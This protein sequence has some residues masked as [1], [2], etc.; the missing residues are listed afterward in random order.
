MTLAGTRRREALV[1]CNIMA[2]L[3]GG[4]PNREPAFAGGAEKSILVDASY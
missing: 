2:Y 1:I 4:H 3:P